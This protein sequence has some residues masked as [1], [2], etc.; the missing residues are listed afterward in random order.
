MK[1]HSDNRHSKITLR[2]LRYATVEGGI[3][4]IFINYTGGVFVTGMALLLGAGDF[5]IGLL[6]AIPF[7]AQVAQIA[8]DRLVRLVGNRKR[9]V[10]IFS[11][12]GRQFW[13]LMLPVLY[14]GVDWGLE[15]LLVVAAV[16]GVGIMAATPAWMSWMADIVPER[17]RGRYFGVRSAVLAAVTVVAVLGGGV[18]LDTTRAAG[19]EPSGYII[20]VGVSCVAAVAALLTLSRIPDPR[21]P[22]QTGFGLSAGLLEPLQNGVF[23]R[24]LLAFAAWNLSIGIAAPFFAPHMLNNLGMS[25]TTIAVYST[26]AAL[27]AV[28]LNKPWGRL[29]DR[30]GSKPVIAICAF[31]VAAV[32]LIWLFPRADFRW[33]LLFEAAYSGAFW[34]GFN[35]AAFNIPIANSPKEKR[36]H[37]LAFFNVATGAAF[38]VSSLLGGVLA[39]AWQNVAFLIGPQRVVNYHLLFIISA[40]LRLVAG[41]MLLGF[42]EPKEKRIPIMI[43]FM[44]YAILKRISLGRQLF[45]RPPELTTPPPADDK[46]QP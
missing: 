15:I 38:F 17:A 2:W 42:H 40:A 14:F 24:L 18:I 35:L 37:Y 16:S 5:Q 22:V 6:A 33:I 23:R 36:T 29:I 44:G 8:S 25:F 28:F 30:F 31:G 9:M 27:A 46:H 43:Q 45:P 20:I 7:L 19:R 3:A 12:L 21:G 4:N 10:I 1:P 13:W 41:A 26:I 11:A 39:E 34:T 32:P